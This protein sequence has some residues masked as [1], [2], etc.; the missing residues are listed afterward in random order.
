V[1][2]S[3]KVGHKP[4]RKYTFGLLDFIRFSSGASRLLLII[5]FG[6]FADLSMKIDW[7]NRS[8]GRLMAQ[9]A[10]KCRE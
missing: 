8:V 6:R 4:G 1:A 7:T 10:I 5:C 3:T 9:V 2:E